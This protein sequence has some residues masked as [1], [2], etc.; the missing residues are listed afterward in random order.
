MM[1]FL[2]IAAVGAGMAA[3]VAGASPASAQNYPYGYSNN[4]GSGIVGAIIN[5]VTGGG[6]GQYPMGNYGYAQTDART[7]VS[8]CVAAVEQGRSGYSQGYSQGYGYQGQGYSQG[9]RGQGYGNQRYGGGL[10]VVGITNVERRSN[11]GLRV[12][13]IVQSGATAGYGQQGYGQQGYYGYEGQGYLGQGGGR[14]PNNANNGYNQGYGN[15]AYNNGY[16]GNGYANNG[17]ANNG[18]AAQVQSRFS[19]KVDSRGVVTD[20]RVDQN[21]GYRRGY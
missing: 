7:S 9:Y 16:G 14:P 5:S 13:G 15:Q 17:Y 11:G 1:K 12:S 21:T 2:K 10:R 6:Y 3:I 8:Q 20:V 18:Y 4:S 19:C